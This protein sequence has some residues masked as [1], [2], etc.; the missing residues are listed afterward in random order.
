MIKACA[1][2]ALPWRAM[3]ASVAR[4]RSRAAPRHPPGRGAYADPLAVER[5]AD[6][7]LV[8][9]A[10]ADRRRRL[11]QPLTGSAARTPPKQA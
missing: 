11:V 10:F 6:R 4:Q 3:R 1:R 8:A 5:V 9:A 7:L 2:L